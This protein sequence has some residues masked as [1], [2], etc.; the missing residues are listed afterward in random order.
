MRVLSAGIWLTITACQL[1]PDFSAFARSGSLFIIGRYKNSGI[2]PGLGAWVHN[3]HPIQNR[4]GTTSS[5]GTYAVHRDTSV[6]MFDLGQSLN[7]P[8]TSSVAAKIAARPSTPVHTH[9]RS[10]IAN[11]LGN[12]Q[13]PILLNRTVSKRSQK[14]MRSPT[15]PPHIQPRRQTPPLA[16]HTPSSSSN[17]SSN[18]N[19]NL[20]S[21]TSPL[22]SPL[23]N[24]STSS[25]LSAGSSYHSW[26]DENIKKS[27][28][29]QLV[30]YDSQRSAW[31]D[32][33]NSGGPRVNEADDLSDT[34]ALGGPEQV[35]R[36]IAGLT[37]GDLA[38]VQQKLVANA[39]S[40]KS[41][42]PPRSPTRRRRMSN[43]RGSFSPVQSG[44]ETGVSGVP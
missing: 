42:D 27:G 12:G 44:R 38:A 21:N 37:K 36:S 5:N 31:Q 33:L 30:E 9:T 2:I 8:R 3:Q 23:L 35:L 41:F 13:D 29:D 6:S 43:S 32:I 24:T 10:P 34:E 18:V 7:S 14:R 16:L 26:T 40:R 4:N 15:P 19:L 1:H 20:Y 17:S 25:L 28:W 11:D 39:L 22:F